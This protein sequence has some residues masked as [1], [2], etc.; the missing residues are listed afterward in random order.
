L[1]PEEQA[2]YEDISLVGLPHEIRAYQSTTPETSEAFLR[3]FWLRKDPFKTS[4]GAMRR[5][6]HYRRVWYARTFFGKKKFPYDRRGE[7][8]IRYGEPDFQS[9]WNDLNAQIPLDVQRVQEKMAY[10]LYGEKSLSMTFVGPV[11]PIRTE[12]VSET[13]YSNSAYATTS[14][15][16]QTMDEASLGLERYKPI[17]ISGDWSS[18]P[19]SVWIY[20]D[21]D[22]GMEV[23]FTD[24]FHSGI[25]EFAPAPTLSGNDIRELNMQR[26]GPMRKMINQINMHSPAALI[27]RIASKEPERYN[28]AALEPMDFYY[29]ALSFRGENGTVDVQVNIGL[30][31]DKVARPEDIDT[32]VVIE[33]RVALIDGRAGKLAKRRD[34]LA[35]P[36]S[37]ESRSSNLMAM[38]RVDL[39]VTSGVY[40]LAVEA[41]RKNTDML[42]VYRQTVDLPNYHSDRLM[43]SDLQIAQRIVEIAEGAGS[44]FQR[45][46][47]DILPA[48]ART[49]REGEPL[50]VYFEIYNLSR[51]DFGNTRYEVSYEVRATASTDASGFTLMPRIRNR[52]GE[53]IEVR[54][55]QIGTEESVADFVELDLGKANPGRYEL[56]MVVKDLNN[57][58][59]ATRESIFKI[60]APARR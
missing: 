47:L 22:G 59:E 46:T 40:E 27:A 9:A 3:T 34:D 38:D 21:I 2:F 14:Q 23:S 48:P 7:V 12:Q 8:Y 60:S 39:Q 45:G 35:I 32:T 33:R 56:R 17:S 53:A 51:D 43:L 16:L 30:P 31:I 10:Q 29:E 54:Y 42:Q 13:S 20:T 41:W 5:A 11:Y 50:F 49:F 26:D 55:E 36:I 6:E 24:D 28:F 18:V 25:Y 44:V 58:K 37:D 1:P 57:E 52:S 19:W 15:P 4:G